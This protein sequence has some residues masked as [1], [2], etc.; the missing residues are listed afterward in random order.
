MIFK[1]VLKGFKL[2]KVGVEQ[3]KWLNRLCS[4]GRGPV[5]RGQK[6]SLSP[7]DL[8]FPVKV[9]PHDQPVEV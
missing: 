4:S 6:V 7:S 8:L 2:K 5:E 3:K 1:L 9:E